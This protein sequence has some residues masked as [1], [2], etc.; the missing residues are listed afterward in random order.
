MSEVS[1][2]IGLPVYNG[3]AYLDAALKSLRAQSRGDFELIVCDNASTDDTPRIIND[4]AAQ[5]PRLRVIRQPRNI[6]SVGNFITA[7]NA[8]RA[9]HFM[10]A[11]SDDKWSPDWV[12]RL[13]PVSQ[14]RHCMAFGRVQMIEADGK[15]RPHAV[16]GRDLSFTGPAPLRRLRYFLQPAFL[17]K[18]NPFYSIFP[19]DLLT[20]DALVPFRRCEHGPD[21]LTL[22]QLLRSAELVSIDGPL[23][24]KRHHTASAAMAKTAHRRFRRTQLPDY[25]SLS[26]PAEKPALIAAFPIAA[27]L[28]PLRR[29]G[30]RISRRL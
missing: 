27:A 6:G 2:S 16:N 8:A 7:L 20:E 10:W 12:E 15:P 24:Y 5:D 11:A 9:P 13:L 1:L 3:A 17:G 25:L 30:S 18:A 21:L 26:S 14:S 4:H 29:I 19:R 22:Y 23:I 28:I